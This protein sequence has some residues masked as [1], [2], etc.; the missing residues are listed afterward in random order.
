MNHCG[1][2]MSYF[3]HLGH[4]HPY[5][6]PIFDIFMPTLFIFCG[7]FNP[8][9]SLKIL[10]LYA[11]INNW[12]SGPYGLN[13]KFFYFYGY[14]PRRYFVLWVPLINATQV[15]FC[16]VWVQTL[17]QSVTNGKEK[18]S[19]LLFCR[20]KSDCRGT[21]GTESVRILKSTAQDPCISD[22]YNFLIHYKKTSQPQ[23]FSLCICLFFIRMLWLYV[24]KT[25]VH[26]VCNSVG[27][28]LWISCFYKNRNIS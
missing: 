14:A 5:F 12:E 7:N 6:L 8:K 11:S 27:K 23:L 25:N 4:I 19:R 9:F 26:F 16:Y 10:T 15:V 3:W 21:L 18:F 20:L 24:R 17:F 22:G 13:M 28:F 1:S 2:G